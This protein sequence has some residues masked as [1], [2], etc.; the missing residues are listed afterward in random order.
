MIPASAQLVD[1][2]LQGGAISDATW[3][4]FLTASAREFDSRRGRS[5]PQ[6]AVMFEVCIA[7]LG[8]AGSLRRRLQGGLKG[9]DDA[10]T[11]F[12]AALL[13]RGVTDLRHA[14]ISESA[15]RAVT[16]SRIDRISR[17]VQVAAVAAGQ[18]RDGDNRCHREHFE[19][20]AQHIRA[21]HPTDN[22]LPRTADTMEAYFLKFCADCQVSLPP[23]ELPPPEDAR[24]EI[25]WPMVSGD[26]LGTLTRKEM[27]LRALERCIEG[28]PDTHRDAVKVQHRIGP[29]VE[30]NISAYCTRIGIERRAFYRRVEEANPMLL[31]CL[32]G[33][34]FGGAA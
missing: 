31:A 26:D 19:A 4:R 8:D 25:T 5:G 24:P 1:E 13:I 11:K 15:H 9:R 10:P 6:R 23:E 27:A 16:W 34:G 3:T 2:I 20:V 30:L 21:E 17:H 22:N 14:Y 32:E 28:L 12:L 7:L 33:S 29:V 18:A